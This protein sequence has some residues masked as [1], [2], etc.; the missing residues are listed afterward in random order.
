[1]IKTGLT[2]PLRPGKEIFFAL[3]NPLYNV[4]YQQKTRVS[5]KIFIWNTLYNHFSMGTPCRNWIVILKA[6]T[7]FTINLIS[8][9]PQKL[10]S[11]IFWA[12]IRFHHYPPLFIS[13]S[14]NDTS[15]QKVSNTNSNAQ[16][17]LSGKK[18]P[19]NF[20]KKC[21]LFKFTLRSQ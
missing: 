8:I 2:F 4:F 20:D 21:Q 14:H 15:N 1:M 7:V 6:E 5:N 17:I 18:R 3:R 16:W 13:S 11:K 12:N 9:V 19:I 10:S